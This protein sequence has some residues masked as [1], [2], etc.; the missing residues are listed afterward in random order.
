MVEIGNQL[1]EWERE[2]AEWL[3][4]VRHPSPSPLARRRIWRKAWKR[5]H[6]R[7]VR[8]LPLVGLRVRPSGL[9]LLVALALILSSFGTVLAAQGS[10]PDG[11]LYPVKR[12]SE[13][14]WLAFTPKASKPEVAM[15][16]ALRRMGEI[17]YLLTKGA[18]IP[19]GLPA[20]LEAHLA[21]AGGE[22][23]LIHI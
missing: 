13:E 11:V 23:S 12:A 3:R 20:A 7:P 14:V 5:A 15:E 8:S 21:Q 2:I 17:E 19:E 9:A 16:L 22:L 4:A 6:P 10:M 18:E 1:A